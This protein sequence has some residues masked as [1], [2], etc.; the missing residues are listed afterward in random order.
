MRVIFCFIFSILISINLSAQS[1]SFL[2]E[3]KLITVVL[4]LAA[5]LIG[6]FAYLFILDRKLTK[7]ENQINNE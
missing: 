2:S 7:I 3:G 1:G 4:V 5:I 6:V